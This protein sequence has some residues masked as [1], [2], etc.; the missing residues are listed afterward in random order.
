MGKKPKYKT[1]QSYNKW[2]N[3]KYALLAGTFA[4]PIIP[5]TVVT[6][7]NWNE[8]FSKS[9]LSLPFGF[10]CLILAV[11]MAILGILKSNVVFKKAD[12]ALFCLAGFFAVIGL[13]CL[14]LASLFTQIGM[15]WL[16]VAGGL[17][18]SGTCLAVEKYK[19]EPNVVYY[20][21]LIEENCLDAKSKRQKAR[22]E[23]ARKDAE[24]DAK[25]QA[26]D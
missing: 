18:G 17:L 7:I 5:A 14:F 20:K 2:R 3:G 8:W 25:R 1:V 9:S 26:V 4:S 13:S 19:I 10:A 22:E 6:A 12:V 11:V 21:K 23:Q 16:Y 24:E 15:M